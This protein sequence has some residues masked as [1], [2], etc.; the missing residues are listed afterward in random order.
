MAISCKYVG[1]LISTDW[2]L[3]LAIGCRG[4]S[5]GFNVLPTRSTRLDF[6]VL[7]TK[8]LRVSPLKRAVNLP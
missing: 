5:E 6:G 4:H 3:P 1:N 8:A 2:Q 7:A